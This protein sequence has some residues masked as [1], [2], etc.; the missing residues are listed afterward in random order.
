MFFNQRTEAVR[1]QIRNL[2]HERDDL[3]DSLHKT[4]NELAELKQKKKME[5][6]D[7]RHLVKIKE[8]KLAIEYD[9]KEVRLERE[10]QAVIAE[11]KDEYRDKMEQELQKQITRMQK[12]YGEILGRL[13]NF[14]VR[15]KGDV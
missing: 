4:R 15:L 14:N 2:E 12:M 8:E 3:N 1:R 10:Q 7:I 9:R 6:E 5:G 13:P 11:V